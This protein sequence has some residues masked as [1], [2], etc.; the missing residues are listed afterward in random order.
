MK[1]PRHRLLLASLLVLGLLSVWWLASKKTA[2][3]PSSAAVTPVPHAQKE[4]P[5]PGAIDEATA[6][7]TP[8][9]PTTFEAQ[10]KAFITAFKTPINFFGRVLD[11]HGEPVAEAD[12]RLSANDKAFGGQPTKYSRKTGAAGEFSITGIG[13]LTLAVEVSKPGYRVLP[14]VYRKTTSSGLFEYGLSRG[15]Y[16]SSEA[17]PTIFTLHK[18]GAIEPLVQV[19]EKNFRMARDGTPVLIAVDPQGMHQVTVR[20]WNQELQRPAGQRQ[21]DWRLEVSVSNGGLLARTDAFAFEAPLY[22]YLPSDT[23][24]M[25]ASLG[26]QWRSFA[27][28]SYFIRFDDGT[29]ARAKLEMHAAGD[30]FVAWE[31]FF[32]PKA[33]SPNL[34]S[35]PPEQSADR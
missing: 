5:A 2:D 20:C 4:V 30:H 16:Q 28:R 33:G 17:A 22:G 23:I 27:E 21:Y 35:P 29:F 14:P 6:P 8:P 26:N 3:Q 13:G 18:P 11:Q 25:P 9:P 32:N 10:E 1:A 19:G 24:E 15:P 12:V 31:S 34:E 7:P